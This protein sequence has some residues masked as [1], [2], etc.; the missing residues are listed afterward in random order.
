MLEST[1]ISQTIKSNIMCSYKIIVLV[2]TLVLSSTA[3]VHGDEHRH[4]RTLR[5]S[6]N[7]KAEQSATEGK[8]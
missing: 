3:G 6:A 8:N 2:V 4:S 5:A 7:N 1:Q